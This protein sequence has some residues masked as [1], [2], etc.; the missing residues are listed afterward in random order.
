VTA[1]IAEAWMKRR[2]EASFVSKLTDSLAEVAEIEDWLSYATDCGYLNLQESTELRDGYQGVMKTLN[3][4]IF[5]SSSW[6][7]KETGYK[8]QPSRRRQA[9]SYKPQATENPPQT[10]NHMPQAT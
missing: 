10:T 8:A 5:Y 2:Y 7:S 6:C 1:N 4:M 9:T 3:A